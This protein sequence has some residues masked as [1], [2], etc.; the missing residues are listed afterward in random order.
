MALHHSVQ[1]VQSVQEGHKDS[2][3]LWSTQR[4]ID[5]KLA[6]QMAGL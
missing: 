3:V 4:Q 6:A 2:D 5:G 1:T